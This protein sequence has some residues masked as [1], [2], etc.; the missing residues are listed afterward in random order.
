VSLVFSAA[1]AA[2]GKWYGGVFGEASWLLGALDLA[3]SLG[4]VTVVFALMYKILPRVQIGWRDVWIGAAV[5]AVLFT[6]GKLALAFYIGKSDVA[7]GFGAAGSLVIVLVW[8]YYSAQIFLLGA[9][10]TWVYAHAFG[11][12]RG[13]ERPATAKRSASSA[14]A[15]PVEASY[16]RQST[17]MS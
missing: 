12:R 13:E 9:E 6:L 2:F 3:V 11:S 1:L 5:T 4:A 10:F 7:S 15:E 8:V 16:L 14:G 17:R